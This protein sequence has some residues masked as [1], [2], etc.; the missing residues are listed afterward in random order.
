MSRPT[1]FGSDKTISI[2][3]EA[4]RFQDMIH[5]AL[6]SMHAAGGVGGEAV[7]KFQVDPQTLQIVI[8]SSRTSLKALGYTVFLF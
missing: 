4:A 2:A 7:M 6:G 1:D 8:K 5:D 3:K